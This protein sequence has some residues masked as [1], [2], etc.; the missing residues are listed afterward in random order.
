MLFKIFFQKEPQCIEKRFKAENYSKKLFLEFLLARLY[1]SSTNS[2]RDFSK[3]FWK[4]IRYFF[5]SLKKNLLDLFQNSKNFT[6]DP[7]K[8]FFLKMLLVVICGN[9]EIIFRCSF[10]IPLSFFDVLRVIHE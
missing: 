1:N 3:N 2:S 6:M 10:R 9:R 8:N 7:I 4:L 5:M